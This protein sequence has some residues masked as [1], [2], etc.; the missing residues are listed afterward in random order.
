MSTPFKSLAT[1]IR[2]SIDVDYFAPLVNPLSV[3]A[4]PNQVIDNSPTLEGALTGTASSVNNGELALLWELVSGPGTAT[5]GSSG[6]LVTTFQVSTEG[7]YVFK[8]TATVGEWSES[9]ETTV[10]M[11]AVPQPQA[12]LACTSETGTATLCGKKEFVGYESVPPKTYLR[13]DVSGIS[14]L[15]QYTSGPCAGAPGPTSVYSTLSGYITWDPVTCAV[16]DQT[17][18]LTLDQGG[19]TVYNG[20]VGITDSSPAS[21]SDCLYSRTYTSTT[22]T[23]DGTGVCCAGDQRATLGKVWTQ[24]LS[25]EDTELNAMARAAVIV[26][27][28]C[29]AK[30][31]ARGAG[32]YSFQFVAVGY[33][34]SCS[35]LQAGVG[36]VAT[37]ELLEEDYGGGNPGASTQQYQFTAGGTTHLISD[38]VSCPSGKQV[39]VQNVSIAFAP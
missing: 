3:D 30:L 31:E 26:G 2:G 1:S 16:N 32:D 4:G 7:T 11:Y 12:A 21:P 22:R 34:I 28:A 29:T 6:A 18:R 37:V 38:V 13:C 19:A 5:F 20:T 33:D 39:T 15:I 10:V 9:D 14:D 8:L 36:Y 35:N 27:T 24:T 25:D 17:N 23:V